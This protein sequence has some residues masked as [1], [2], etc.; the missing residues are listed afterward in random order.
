LAPFPHK[1]SRFGFG[2]DELL[3]VRIGPASPTLTVATS[4]VKSVCVG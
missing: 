3:A 2:H 1:L 4:G